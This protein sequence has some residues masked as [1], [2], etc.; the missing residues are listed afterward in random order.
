MDRDGRL[1][2]ISEVAE[3]TGLRPSA[4]RYYEEVGLIAAAER[5]SGRRYF[6]R[7]VL[8]RLALIALCQDV[9]FTIAEIGHLF[10]GERESRQR[11]QHLAEQK[12]VEVDDRIRQARTMKSLLQ[13]AQQCSCGRL[14]ECDLVAHAARRRL[15]R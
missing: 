3:T 8:D 4:L 13:A 11:W 12:L 5:R 7:D 14:A 9:G 1:L 10:G 15:A 6:T 2:S